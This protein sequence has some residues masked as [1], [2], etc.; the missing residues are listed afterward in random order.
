MHYLNQLFF[1]TP[2][3][4]DKRLMEKQ[5][6]WCVAWSWFHSPVYTFSCHHQKSNL[7]HFTQ[8]CLLSFLFVMLC[9][10]LL[11]FCVMY[12]CSCNLLSINMTMT[13]FCSTRKLYNRCCCAVCDL[14]FWN[15]MYY[16][17]FCLKISSAY[18]CTYFT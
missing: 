4:R 7:P 1:A 15:G 9:C 11:H 16:F 10:F 12:T 18:F 3:K 17:T 6:V 2:L 5:I 13:V 14:L 8:A